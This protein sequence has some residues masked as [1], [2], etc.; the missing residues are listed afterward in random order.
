[1]RIL[2][3]HLTYIKCHTNFVPTM[4]C[5]KDLYCCL[6]VMSESRRIR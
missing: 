3:D 5:F 4:S 1:M 6:Y 2:K